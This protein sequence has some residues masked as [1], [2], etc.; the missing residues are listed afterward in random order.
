MVLALI[1]IILHPCRSGNL[2]ACTRKTKKRLRGIPE[3]ELAMLEY[4]RTSQNSRAITSP[5]A[6]TFL[7]DIF[8][9]DQT[10]EGSPDKMLLADSKSGEACDKFVFGISNR[11]YKDRLCVTHSGT[12]VRVEEE[13]R[14]V[15]MDPSREDGSILSRLSNS[16]GIPEPLGISVSPLSGHDTL[17]GCLREKRTVLFPRAGV[18]V[19]EFR[20]LYDNKGV[21]LLVS[22]RFGIQLIEIV[23]RIHSVPI[24]HGNLTPRNVFV[25]LDGTDIT[26]LTIGKFQHARN[27]LN[28]FTV[29]AVKDMHRIY[30]L[31]INLS[32]NLY[33]VCS[34]LPACREFESF[35]AG[36]SWDINGSLEYAAAAAALRNLIEEVVSNK[37]G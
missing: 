16:G 31:L 13:Y 1:V 10:E 7:P 9:A 23:G 32:P 25:A 33:H 36:S 34:I 20:R 22:L 29:A 3:Q 19:E 26:G 17:N 21:P 24:F 28:E 35:T 27:S 11:R 6:Q 14:C 8:V 37:F 5:T 30:Q 18:T 2:L 4:M 15:G 12:T